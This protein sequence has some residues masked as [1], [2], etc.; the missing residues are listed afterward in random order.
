MTRVKRMAAGCAVIFLL[1]G[2]VSG[3]ATIQPSDTVRAQV[4]DGAVA[5]K[6]DTVH[7]FYGMSKTAKEQ[8]CIDA[9]VPVYRL[10]GSATGPIYGSKTE[11]GRIKVTKDLGEHYIEAVVLEGTI[12][13]GDIAMLS[14]S[15]CLIN[16]PS[17]KSE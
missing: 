2:F 12:R 6:G 14:H 1:A 5:G 17:K 7:L 15:E 16:V 10:S 13:D 4:R 9:E 11:V 3:C 8:F